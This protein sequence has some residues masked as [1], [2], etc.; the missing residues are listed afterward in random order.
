MLTSAATFEL[1]CI[2]H[3][4]ING[5]I[6][7][8]CCVHSARRGRAL[9]LGWLAEMPAWSRDLIILSTR[10]DSGLISFCAIPRLL[11]I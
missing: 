11:W 6:P 5:V 2:E 7:V 8:S 9:T 1:I 3:S 4:F 10:S